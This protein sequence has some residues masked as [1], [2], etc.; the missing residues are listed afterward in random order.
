MNKAKK[1]M[2]KVSNSP[3]D[4]VNAPTHYQSKEN[5]IDIDAITC[6]RAAFGDV[7]VKDF[8]LN[9]AMKYVFRSASKGKD[10][11][12]KKAIWYLNKFLELGGYSE[13]NKTQ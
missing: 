7:S 11:D 1:T 13:N 10:E 5:G 2:W 6:M 4:N 12:I 9:N 8:C 3:N